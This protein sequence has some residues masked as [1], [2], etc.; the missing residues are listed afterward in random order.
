MLFREK[1][2]LI[3]KICLIE[4]PFHLGK[5]RVGM[6]LG[7]VT[8]MQ[9]NLVQDLLDQGHSLRVEAVRHSGSFESELSA[10]VKLNQ[11]LKEIIKDAIQDN[12]F[13]FIL[14]G[15]CN[16]C[17]GTLSGLNSEN[18]GIIWL[19][20]H[21][22][23]NTPEITLTNFLDG[24][25]L[26][27]ATGQCYP[28]VWSQIAEI[29]PI[30]ES[31]VLH[32]GERDLDPKERELMISKNITMISTADLKATSVKNVLNPPLQTLKNRVKDVYLHIDID[33][34]DPQEVPGVDYRTPNGLFSTEIKEIIQVIS[35]VLKIRA[36]GFT[37]YNPIRDKNHN[38][39]NV[40]IDL[41]TKITELLSQSKEV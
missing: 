35:K 20:A 16:T 32:I 4:V 18:T 29:E 31:F 28:D 19:D 39:L 5:E 2:D 23:F 8:I 24:M 11:Q 13:P 22:D 40:I 21:G 12:Y 10:I 14:G 41:S 33:I 3:M 37:A 27:I 25:P 6:G 30:D 15:N 26:A 34:L 36:V 7:P 9:S 38:T 17:L 1:V